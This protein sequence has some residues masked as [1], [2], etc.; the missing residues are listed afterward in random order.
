MA[1]TPS[2]FYESRKSSDQVEAKM[3]EIEHLADA[4]DWEKIEGIVERLPDL[5]ARIPQA[6]RRAVTIAA[7]DCIERVR[8]RAIERSEEIGSKLATLKTGRRAAES[9]RVTGALPTAN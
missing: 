8:E 6:E 2:A 3:R 1:A 7:R 4:G 9:Y 5:L